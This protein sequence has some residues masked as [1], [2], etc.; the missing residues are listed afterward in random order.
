MN[1]TAVLLIAFLAI[2]QSLAGQGCSD[3]GFC[4]IP[5]FKPAE[6][7]SKFKLEFRG[8]LEGSEPGALIIS[9]QIWFTYQPTEKIQ[10]SVKAP[11]WLVNDDSLGSV[12]AFNDPI[13]SASFQVY[14]NEKVTVNVTGGFRIGVGN[15]DVL[16]T[17]DVSLPMDYQPSLGTTDLIIGGNAQFGDFSAS[18]A[19][20]YPIWQYNQNLNVVVKNL[21]NVGVDP[22]TLQFTRQPD[23]MLR[24]DKRWNFENWGIQAG[25]LPI[26]HLANDELLS[27]ENTGYVSIEGS[28]GF[29]VNIPFGA[30]YTHNNWT[31]GLDGGFPIVTR[32]SRPDG[33]TR[34]FVL[35]PRVL[36]TFLP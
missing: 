26:Y 29:T 25:I 24:L 4:T 20:Q 15:A 21:D 8:S 22:T 3:A 33:L 18:L 12:S 34:R 9:P 1:K 2:W 13:V 35:Q 7:Q 14:I 32:E 23:I 36:Y 16:G 31:F 17:N 28:Q 6:E 30:W 5:A 19:L 27:T 10:L 11:F